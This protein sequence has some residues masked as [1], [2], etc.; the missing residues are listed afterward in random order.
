MTKKMSKIDLKDR[1]ILYQLD[2]NARQSFAQI[3]KRVGL[4]KNVVAY[5]INSMVEDGLIANFYTVIDTCKLG[6]MW[7]RFHYVFQYTTP[8]IEQDIINYFVKHKNCSI[9]AA[10][11]GMFDLSVS[12]WFK[13]INELYHMWQETQYMFGNYFQHQSFSFLI[14]DVHYRPSYLILDAAQKPDRSISQYTGCTQHVCIDELDYTIL[15]AIDAHARTPTT[16]IAEAL[17]TTPMTVKNRMKKL[18]KTGVINGFRVQY[19]IAQL[20]YQIFKLYL[21]LKEFDKR[22][23]IIKYMQMNPYLKCVDN[24]ACEFHAEF[25]FHLEHIGQLHDIMQATMA[26]FPNAIRN[27]KYLSVLTVYKY[28]YM[29][30]EWPLPNNKN[31]RPC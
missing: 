17:G 28:L 30:E 11:Q 22:N 9:V 4:S 12:L 31:V 1:K 8:E 29:P 7:T 21:Y 23:D 15:Q 25:E 2:L 20:G 3:G 14:G 19:N 24:T 5:R 10:T 13:N 27:Y 26:R 18:I 16:E 6:Y